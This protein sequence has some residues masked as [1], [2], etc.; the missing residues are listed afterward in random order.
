MPDRDLGERVC[1]YVV[2]RDGSALDLAGVRAALQAHHI[3]AYKLPEHLVVVEAL[4]QTKVGK[5][6]KRALREDIVAR[7]NTEPS[8]TR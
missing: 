6:D 4:P 7:L 1:V 8:S 5:I 2:R 3:A